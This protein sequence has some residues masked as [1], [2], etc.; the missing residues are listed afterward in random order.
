MTRVKI[1]PCFLELLRCYCFSFM[2]SL[3][4]NRPDTKTIKFQFDFTNI[5]MD[6]NIKIINI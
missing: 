2:I 6:K 5:I 1:V 3:V 4:N